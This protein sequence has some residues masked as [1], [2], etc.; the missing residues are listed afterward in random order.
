MDM[1]RYTQSVTLKDGSR[2]SYL[3]TASRQ[4]GDIVHQKDR[5]T[6]VNY[7]GVL[8]SREPQ[9]I[10]EIGIYSGGSLAMWRDLWPTSEILGID[11]TLGHMNR[12]AV[13]HLDRVGVHR[14][15]LPMPNM[16]A[17]SL[18]EFDLII[19]DGAH[20]ANS[21]L[22]S[23]AICWPMLR[24][25]GVYIVEDWHLAAFDPVRIAGT[26]GRQVIGTDHGEHFCDGPFPEDSA[27]SVDVRRRLIAV[28]KR[29]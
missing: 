10:L 29:A 5:Q 27:E 3:H 23:F 19:D 25:G 28:Y 18:G 8:G 12:E 2:L 16:S 21:V 13:E 20:G 1:L 6:L 26:L 9:R 14:Q 4:Q 11:I 15:I 17:R 24:R 7:E 22:E